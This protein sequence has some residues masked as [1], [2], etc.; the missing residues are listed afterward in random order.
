[1]INTYTD[2]FNYLRA[3]SLNQSNVDFYDFQDIILKLSFFKDLYFEDYLFEIF[4]KNL[5]LFL[6]INYLIS[7]TYIDHILLDYLGFDS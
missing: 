6:I 4:I 7:Y 5:E 2:I 3:Y 1:M